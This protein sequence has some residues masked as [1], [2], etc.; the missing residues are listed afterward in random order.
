MHR[1]GVLRMRR[2]QLLWLPEWLLAEQSLLS[3]D[4]FFFLTHLLFWSSFVF[5][6][7]LSNIKLLWLEDISRTPGK[8][9]KVKFQAGALL[10]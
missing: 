1:A 4:F 9:R 7:S 5:S 2:E 10:I 8:A 3:T 6:L